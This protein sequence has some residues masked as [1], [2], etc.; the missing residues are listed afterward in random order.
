VLTGYDE[1]SFRESIAAAISLEERNATKLLFVKSWN[2]WAEG[3]TIE[4]IFKE[5]WS[6]GQVLADAL[7]GRT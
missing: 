7:S 1:A 6:A 2:D 4:P 5:S 3:N